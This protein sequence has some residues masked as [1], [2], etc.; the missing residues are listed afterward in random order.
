MVFTKSVHLDEVLD[1]V[2]RVGIVL[3][4][5]LLKQRLKEGIM[6]KMAD[7]T[8]SACELILNSNLIWFEFLWFQKCL[9]V[10][11]NHLQ[12][13]VQAKMV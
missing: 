9:Q 5:N 8:I 13:M 1:E 6:L 10:F 2:Q 4:K 7:L 3:F 12:P 11:S